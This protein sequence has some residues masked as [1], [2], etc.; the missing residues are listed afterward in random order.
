MTW[1]AVALA[2]QAGGF[3]SPSSAFVST[4]KAAPHV[5][6]LDSSATAVDQTTTRTPVG[7]EVL[8]VAIVGAGPAGLA[9]AVGL[10]EKGLKVKVF[11]AAPQITERGAAVFLQVR[12]C[13]SVCQ[14]LLSLVTFLA[15]LGASIG[16]WQ[17]G[18][19]YAV[20][21]R[22]AESDRLGLLSPLS[23]FN[24]NPP[25]LQVA[26]AHGETK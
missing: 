7:Q 15:L 25:P 8:D 24:A 2:N 20:K 5:G 16:Y 19:P 23:R 13:V 6:R 4:P 12:C 1:L 3:V 21:R 26:G 11:E 17:W 14:L 18:S 22:P 9:A 10:K